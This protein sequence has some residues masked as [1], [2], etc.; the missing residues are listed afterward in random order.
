MEFQPIITCFAN[1]AHPPKIAMTLVTDKNIQT[2]DGSSEVNARVIR[3]TT[4]ATVL[5]F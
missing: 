2:T 1:I 4:K 3:A 5:W